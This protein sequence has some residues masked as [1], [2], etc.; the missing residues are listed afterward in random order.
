MHREDLS[1]I[2]EPQ[3][4]ARY[5]KDSSTSQ[6]LELMRGD[7][8][9]PLLDEIVNDMPRIFRAQ[10]AGAL[11]AVV[12]WKIGDRP[13]GGT[14]VYELIISGGTCLVSET[15]VHAPRLTLTIGVVDFVRMTMGCAA[16]VALFMRGRMRSKGD[17]GLAMKFAGLFDIGRF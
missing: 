11:D 9:G 10:S 4:F 13:D 12:H 6:I 16:P 1:F 3:A 7:R 14:D 5:I 15:P 2:R 17:L 8:R